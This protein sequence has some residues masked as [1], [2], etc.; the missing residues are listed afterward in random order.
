MCGIAGIV[1]PRI[2]RIDE[3][4]QKIRQMGLWQFHRGPDEW[5]EWIRDG[6]ALGHNRLSIIDVEYGKQPMASYDG[7]VQVIFNGEIYNFQLLWKELTGRGYQFRTD[8]SDTEV[9][10]HGYCEWGTGVFERLEGMFAIAIWD[11]KKQQLILAR[12]RAGIKP[13]YYS[14]LPENGIV[15]ASEP[16]T[17]LASGLV[18]AELR[19]TSLV[20][21]FMFRA[22]RDP[23]TLFEGISKFPA[24]CWSIY[25]HNCGLQQPVRFWQPE[26]KPTK[27]SL[28]EA[29]EQIV[30]QL[31]AAVLSHSVAD[32]PMGL[33]LSGGVDSSLI[34]ALSSKHNKLDAF[35]IGTDSPYDEIPYAVK[36][37]NHLGL[38]LHT[39]KVTAKDF[40]DKFD[41]W[42][43]FND[44]PV[45]DPSALALMVLAEYAREHGMKVML[46]GEGADELFGGYNS[47]LRY[48]AFNRIAKIPFAPLLG[49]LLANAPHTRNADYL[50]TLGNLHFMGTAHTTNFQ[51][52]RSLLKGELLSTIEQMEQTGFS[53][54]IEGAGKIREAMLFDQIVRLPNDSLPR[55]D[56]AT[57]GV[58]LETRVPFLDTGVINLANSLPD[59]WCINLGQRSGKWLLKRILSELV[60]PEIVYRPKRGFDLPLTG[61]LA[62]DF[63]DIIIHY[64]AEEAVP[65]IEYNFVRQ[66]YNTRP[67]IEPVLVSLLWSWLVLEKWYRLWILGQVQ[68]YRPK[69]ARNDLA[70]N[71]LL[72]RSEG[73]RSVV[74]TK[75]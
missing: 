9:I 19:T 2:K 22:S 58:A 29:K 43:Y 40:L 6:V 34:A 38:T 20:D 47:Y 52:R 18:K 1:Y 51:T 11:N 36:V 15:F 14:Q 8:H 74:S 48:A 73:N 13:L 67:N 30:Q 75:H 64:L 26:V 33:F 17:I 28:A 49:K 31:D 62:D 70:Y 63:Q 5:G 35:T 56:R 53:E 57:M 4:R 44:D 23:Y 7:Q 42:M 72:L 54:R 16:K 60:P 10:V 46:A 3:L 24:G 32:V 59:K 21:Y 37:A 27:Y 45:S 61:W 68:L 41:D 25:K 50:N 12:D 65:G 69:L 39:R 55:T 71:Q 66:I